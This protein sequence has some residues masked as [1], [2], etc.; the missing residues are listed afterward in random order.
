MNKQK[1]GYTRKHIGALSST[2]DAESEKG[3]EN[4]E[5]KNQ[6]ESWPG[7]LEFVICSSA[8]GPVFEQWPCAALRAHGLFPS[9]RIDAQLGKGDGLLSGAEKKSNPFLRAL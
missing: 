4:C 3:A 9:V 8:A 2:Q 7:R 6:R 5:S 1:L